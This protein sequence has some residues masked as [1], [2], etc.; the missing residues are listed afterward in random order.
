MLVHNFSDACVNVHVCLRRLARSCRFGGVLLL[1]GC[2]GVAGDVSVAPVLRVSQKDGAYAPAALDRAVEDF[3]GPS[4]TGRVSATGRGRAA[5]GFPDL[6][7]DSVF[8]NAGAIRYR[9][10]SSQEVAAGVRVER[11]VG[12]TR[13]LQAQLLAG[14]GGARYLLPDGA[15]AFKSPIAIRARSRFA[16]AR[17]G[18]SQALPMGPIP[19]RASLSGGAGLRLTDSRLHV[20]SDLLD[21]RSRNRQTS[22]FADLRLEYRPD[23]LPARGFAEARMHGRQQMLVLRLGLDLTLP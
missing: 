14:R 8:G 17:G 12:A 3:V 22:P 10:R 4:R 9:T 5:S 2:A 7:R 18:L 1:A 20:T 19:G 13:T 6:D 11:A 21:V 16:E 23:A 15:A